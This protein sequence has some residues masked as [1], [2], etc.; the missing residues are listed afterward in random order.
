MTAM[1]LRISG[2][3]YTVH[4][5]AAGVA[6]GTQQAGGNYNIENQSSPQRCSYSQMPG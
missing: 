4:L 1:G 5:C 2:R 6:L 3:S